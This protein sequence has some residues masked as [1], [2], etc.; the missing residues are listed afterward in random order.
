MMTSGYVWIATDWLPFVLDS[1]EPMDPDTMNLLQGVIALRHHTADSNMKNNCR[2]GYWS[3]Y[4]GLSII[5]PEILYKK[6]P[7]T[8]SNS[9]TLSS[10]IWHGETIA[11]PRGWVFPN[12]GK[13]L[14]IGVPNRTT[15]KEFVAKES[16][17][18]GVKGFY[19]E[20]FEAAVALLQY[21]VPHTYILYGDGL[22][23]PIYDNLVGM[24]AENVSYFVCDDEEAPN[25]PK[26]DAHFIPR[27]NP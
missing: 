3:N 16:G 10:V 19:I 27:E 26:E 11:K 18:E 23:N 22:R 17:S 20:V 21:A 1:L 25:T 6:P 4:S 9:Q 2:I 24:V 5:S 12:N 8:S 14:R 13:P 7:N 15:Y